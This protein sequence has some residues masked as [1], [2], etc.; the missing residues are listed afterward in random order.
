MVDM[1][2]LVKRYYYDPA[3]GG[4]NS[5]KRVLPAILNSSKYLRIS[6]PSPYMVLMAVSSV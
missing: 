3:M 5:I 1:W 6:I 4:S 2:E